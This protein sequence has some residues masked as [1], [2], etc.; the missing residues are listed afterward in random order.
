MTDGVGG[1][2]WPNRMRAFVFSYALLVLVT[3]C[4]VCVHWL[5]CDKAN[6]SFNKSQVTQILSTAHHYAPHDLPGFSMTDCWSPYVFLFFKL[7]LIIMQLGRIFYLCIQ[8]YWGLGYHFAW[9]SLSFLR[10]FI[11]QNPH[12]PSKAGP[13]KTV[14]KG[15]G[16]CTL[17]NTQKRPSV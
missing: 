2:L 17:R 13:A 10:G 6:R 8:T 12:S 16:K 5:Y 1:Y 4:Q 9:G 3:K 11:R 14:V 7:E 15:S